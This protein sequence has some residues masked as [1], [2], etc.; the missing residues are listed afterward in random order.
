MTLK[1]SQA[2][3]KLLRMIAVHKKGLV[4]HSKGSWLRYDDTGR[5]ISARVY[6]VLREL[7]MLDV[8][9]KHRVITAKVSK[10]GYNWLI[11]K[12]LLDFNP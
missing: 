8:S 3:E 11:D 10:C 4:I 9:T 5:P 2:Q 12:A 7:G 1:L 6:R